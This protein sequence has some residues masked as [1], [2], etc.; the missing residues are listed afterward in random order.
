MILFA[1]R[2]GQTGKIAKT[3]SD[4]L[5]DAGLTTRTIDARDTDAVNALDFER[6]DL[7]IFGGS[8]HAGGLENELIRVLNAHTRNIANMPRSFFLVLLSAATKDEDLRTTSLADARNKMRN[9]LTLSFDDTELI[10][11][12]LKYSAYSW[13]IRR[14]MRAIAKRAGG[15][16]DMSKDYEYTDWAQVRMYAQR[17]I[18]LTATS[19][20]NRSQPV[21]PPLL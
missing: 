19:T 21:A 8:M 15:D 20:T 7:L 9:Q 18:D 17:L 2:E 5:T 12:A 10:A 13:P 16:T 4:H 11:G 6:F 3:I 1:S 14:I